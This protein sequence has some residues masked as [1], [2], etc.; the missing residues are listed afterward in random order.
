MQAFIKEAVRL[1]ELRAMLASRRQQ[2]KETR[3]TLPSAPTATRDAR[4][5]MSPQEI[6][7]SS[8]LFSLRGR[9]ARTREVLALVL[10][11]GATAYRRPGTQRAA[12]AGNRAR[13]ICAQPL[14]L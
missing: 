10:A 3:A 13:A 11:R 8:T 12:S 9:Q 2:A 5:M 7:C 1:D 4:V 6:R 14:A